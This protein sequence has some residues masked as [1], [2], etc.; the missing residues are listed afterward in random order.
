MIEAKSDTEEELG[1][2][3][4]VVFDLVAEIRGYLDYLEEEREEIQYQSFPKMQMRQIS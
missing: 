4:D 3:H 2:L 1:C